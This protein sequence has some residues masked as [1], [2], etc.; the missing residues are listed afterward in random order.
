MIFGGAW[1]LSGRSAFSLL[2]DL[3]ILAVG[4]GVALLILIW[5]AH[6]QADREAR[7][8]RA[9]SESDRPFRLLR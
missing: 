1:L 5:R 9:T 3:G 7:A 2:G 4:G 6:I 8:S